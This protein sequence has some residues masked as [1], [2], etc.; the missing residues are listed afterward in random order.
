MTDEVVRVADQPPGAQALAPPDAASNIGAHPRLP[1]LGDALVEDRQR[2]VGQQRREM[3]S[4]MI[5]RDAGRPS[6]PDVRSATPCS[7]R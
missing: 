2:D 6:V 5:A 1:V 4:C 7:I 3:L